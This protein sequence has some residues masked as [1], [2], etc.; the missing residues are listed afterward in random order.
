MGKR[1]T[2]EERRG[3]WAAALAGRSEADKVDYI[4]MKTDLDAETY[5]KPL[6]DA[7]GAWGIQTG[8]GQTVSCLVN[9]IMNPWTTANGFLEK[10][11]ELFKAGIQDCVKEMSK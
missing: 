9:T 3:A 8:K 10:I 11:S 1:Y 7:L 4:L 5:A 2:D 6:E